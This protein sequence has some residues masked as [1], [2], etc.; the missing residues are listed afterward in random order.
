TII[1]IPDEAP[2]EIPRISTSSHHGHSQ[3]N[4]S[5]TNA[6]ITTNYDENFE[7]DREGCLGY[8]KDRV[9]HITDVLSPYVEGGFLFSG[10]TTE[11]VI[12]NLDGISP[13]DIIKS[14][15]LNYQGSVQPHDLE[16][17]MTFVVDDIHYVNI[18]FSNM[19]IYEG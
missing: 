1:P 4:V 15:F 5:L 14:K 10:L 8:L 9:S 19:R 13:L 16:Y 17:K 18:T 7:Q 3:L 12:E 2:E 11:L 6:Q